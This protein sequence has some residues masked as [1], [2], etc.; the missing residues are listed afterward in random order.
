MTH[1]TTSNVHLQEDLGGIIKKQKLSSPEEKQSDDPGVT[2][3]GRLMKSKR[4]KL[5]TKITL[6]S[7]FG[8]LCFLNLLT[9]LLF[10]GNYISGDIVPALIVE[11]VTYLLFALLVFV[12]VMWKDSKFVKMI[13][14]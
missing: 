10:L 13:Y 12:H 5:L 6:Y 7:S 14:M 2:G 11:L 1:L 4:C 8:F 3:I 9:L